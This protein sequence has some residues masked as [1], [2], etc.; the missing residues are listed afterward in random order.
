MS[1]RDPQPALV[2]PTLEDVARVAGVSRATVSRV[3]NGIRNVDPG[4]QEKV[5]QAVSATGCAPNRAARSL[6]TRRTGSIA[7]VVSGAGDVAVIGFDDSSVALACRPQLTTVRQP[8][9]EMAAEMA[10]L[11][12]AHIEEPGR[13]AN[14][15][16]FEPTLVVRQ[17]A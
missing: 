10:R 16:I 7:L 15:V 8:M 11:L 13:R 6:V 4:I 2:S 1:S 3:V 12:P 5:R 17:S 9:E 14:P